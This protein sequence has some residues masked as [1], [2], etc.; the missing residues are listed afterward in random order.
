MKKLIAVIASTL[1]ASTSFAGEATFESVQQEFRQKAISLLSEE[2][3]STKDFQARLAGL[4]KETF[5]AHP[6][7]LRKEAVKRFKKLP[8]FPAAKLDTYVEH[9]SVEL[10][11]LP[12]AETEWI[13]LMSG[14][15]PAKVANWGAQIILSRQLGAEG[16]GRR[17]VLPYRRLSGRIKWICRHRRPGRTRRRDG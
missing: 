12:P 11:S 16:F 2:D 7:L 6:N 4:A 8:S 15:D 1:L 10:P 9:K 13:L 5:G 17:A 14:W 3:V